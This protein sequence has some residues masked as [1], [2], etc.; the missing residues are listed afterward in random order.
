MPKLEPGKAVDVAR[1]TI[2]RFTQS[3][4]TVRQTI[5]QSITANPPQ[6]TEYGRSAEN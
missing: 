5:K 6:H 1:T 2:D 3:N 4:G